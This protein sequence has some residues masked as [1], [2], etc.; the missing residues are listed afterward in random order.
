MTRSPHSTLPAGGGAKKVLYT[1]MSVKRVGLK[2][3]AKALTSHNACKACGF[4][5]GGQRGGMTNEMD[6]FPSVCNKSVQA[7]I[8][9]I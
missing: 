3:A 4:G 5:M 8:T 6:E 1:L 9:D 2:N 7:Q